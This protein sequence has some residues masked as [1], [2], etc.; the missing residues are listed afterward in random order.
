M[1][2]TVTNNGGSYQLPP[3]GNH[4]A[5]CIRVIDLGTQKET[6]N[7]KPKKYHRGILGWELLEEKAVFDEERGEE[8][9]FVSKEYTLSLSERANLR[10]DLESWRGKGFSEAELEA[11]DMSRLLGALC[12]VNV[13]HR[14]S[15]KKRKYASVNGITPLPKGM[16]DLVPKQVLPSIKY[17]IEDR[18]GGA[19]EE[20]PE[21]IQEKIMAS[22]EWEDN[23]RSDDV[24]LE[25][26]NTKLAAATNDEP[27][28]VDQCAC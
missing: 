28:P 7:G 20:L 23:S 9:F 6:Y 10:H 3:E 5:R 26:V 4:L 15:A 24:E 17:L 14:V 16:K 25:S 1:S 22:E 11:F 21:F 18:R 2:L 27:V 13:I 8:P 19:F 12:M